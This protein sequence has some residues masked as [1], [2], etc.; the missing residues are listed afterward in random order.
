M[1]IYTTE[2]VTLGKFPFTIIINQALYIL[3]KFT[4]VLI[5]KLKLINY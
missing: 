3:R 1:V 2:Y 5:N 4:R